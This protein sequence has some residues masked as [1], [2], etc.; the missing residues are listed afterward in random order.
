MENLKEVL[1]NKKIITIIIFVIIMIGVGGYL[2]LNN[3]KYEEID[4]IKTLEKIENGIQEKTINNE[5]QNNT[6]SENEDIENIDSNIIQEENS[7][8]KIAIHITGEVKKK[9]ILYLDKGARIVD[10][11]K[12]AG[13]ATKNANLDQVNLAYILE[14]G[15]K[16]Y[17]PN[18]KEK[19]ETGAY[20]IESS[21]DNVLVE[22]G[23]NNNDSTGNDKTEKGV[24]E[25]VNINQANQ[26]EL[27]TLP[28]IGPS[29]AQRIIEYRKNN[30]K[31]KKIEDIQNVKG[32]GDNKYS[33][34]KDN[35]CI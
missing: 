11:V 12:A 24:S 10:A 19:I 13:G 5:E 2:V 31:F 15:Q 9:G 35:I 8:E 1:Q 18:K 26:T 30:G 22:N 7:E 4:N 6:N 33:N 27:E 34:I 25:K 23:K 16:I 28:G 14:D 17:I 20:I 21:G 29:L 3:N 32:I